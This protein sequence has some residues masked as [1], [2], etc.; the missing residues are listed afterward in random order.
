MQKLIIAIFS[1]FWAVPTFSQV[2]VPSLDPV[3]K[4]ELASSIAW[5]VG[6][7]VGINVDYLSQD[8][9]A[10]NDSQSKTTKQS[11]LIS[12]QPGNIVGEL[13]YAPYS[14]TKTYSFGAESINVDWENDNGVE[15]ALRLAIR[16]DR[17]VSV[18]IGYEG[19]SREMNDYQY[20]YSHYEG[21]FSL[22]LFEGLLFL[23]A[24]MQRVTE[25]LGS[26]DT[27]KLNRVITGAAVQIGDPTDTFFK[28]EVALKMSPKTESDNNILGESPNTTESEFAVELMTGSFFVSYRI[29][30]IA[31]EEYINSEDFT[32]TSNR[33]GL[34]IKF[35]SFT[36]SLYRNAWTALLN[37]ELEYFDIYQATVGFN[38]L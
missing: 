38:F 14:E 7:T 15:Y 26:D 1:I 23:G 21:S 5:R 13:F 16:G 20:G 6:S 22:R 37:E 8:A 31:Y 32:E 11:V 25:N 24:G 4:C 10:S 36:L 19:R 17:T 9:D 33:Y 3:I 30:Q 27:R 18:G 29:K 28:T 12:Y 34:G 35:G 2:V